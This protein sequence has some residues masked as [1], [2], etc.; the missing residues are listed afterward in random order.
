M[1]SIQQP[2]GREKIYWNPSFTPSLYFTHA[3]AYI[4]VGNNY[5][6]IVYYTTKHTHTQYIYYTLYL[7]LC[8]SIFNMEHHYY[9]TTAALWN[10]IFEQIIIKCNKHIE[11]VNVFDFIYCHRFFVNIYSP[12]RFFCRAS[13]VPDSDSEL[14]SPARNS[15][16]TQC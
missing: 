7:L 4:M 10:Y 8:M 15:T 3:S 2:T 6:P 16:Q 5:N 9:T 14:G 11:K 12:F 1:R 13:I